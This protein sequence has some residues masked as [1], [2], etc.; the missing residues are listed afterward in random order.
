MCGICGTAGFVDQPLLES[1]TDLLTHR[2]PDDRGTYVSR[3]ATAASMVGLGNRRL[4]IIDLSPA[5]HMPMCNEDGTVWVTYNGETYNFPELRADLVARQH[6]FRSHADTEVIVHGY[7]EYGVDIFKRLNA[8]FAAAIWDDRRQRLVLARDRLGIKPLY[9]CVLG[10][11]LLF[12]SE[13]KSLLRC[14]EVPREVDPTA[15]LS[16]LTFMWVP[17]PQTMFRGIH[18]LLP[19]HYLLWEKGRIAVERYWDL[20]EPAAERLPDERYH[21]EFGTLLRGAV[22][23]QLIS[24][25][26]LGVFLSGG[27]DSSAILA[28]ATQITGR[29]VEAY[30][31]TYRDEDAQLEQSAEDAHYARLVAKHF[32]ANYHE[33]T[34]SPSVAELLPRL[35]WH[36]DEPIADP[37]LV[38]AYSIC[39]KARPDVT[40]LLSGMGA[41]EL[42]AG[43]NLHQAYALTR[44]A[45]RVPRAVREHLLRPALGWVAQHKDHLGPL[46]PGM[47]LA[48]HRYFDRVLAGVELSDEDL[49]L[50]Y[51]ACSG[52]LDA[53]FGLLNGDMQHVVAGADPAARQHAYLDT[54]RAT[55]VLNRILYTD[56]KTFL[57]DLNLT[58]TDKMSMATSVEVRVPLLDAD[59]VD[60]VARLPADL[61]LRGRTSK[62]ILRHAMQNVLPAG[63]L[64]RRKA[65]FGS[66]MRR[67][68]SHDLRP[69]VADLL[70]PQA[71]RRRGLF[72]PQVVDGIV[73]ASMSGAQDNTFSILALI[74]FELWYRIFIERG[75]AIGT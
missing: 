7:E 46:R 12:A 55:D 21:D 18:K 25:V 32:N 58:Y 16:Y 69:M 62:F 3:G 8:M 66:P 13:I 24:D 28:L 72:D 45:R 11:R 61:K 59:L 35:V 54:R 56:S 68:L 47:A 14:A 30:T 9:Y 67:W 4:S 43:Y 42:L 34:L 22:E 33:I 49:Y 57:P 38:S 37:A 53:A 5:G 73:Q 63:V 44:A 20:P 29:P 48:I 10:E 17:G 26:P 19:G 65:P 1:M 39:E 23:R 52:P 71:V 40:V 41:D 60:F 2:G 50:S 27:V 31:I 51:R 6:T 64:S 15:L 36:L 75:E 70:S 74:T